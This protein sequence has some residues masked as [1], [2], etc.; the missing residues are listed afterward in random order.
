M[1]STQVLDAKG[2][3]VG[4]YLSSH[5]TP[6]GEMM[7]IARE[8]RFGGGRIVVPASEVRRENDA[9]HLP[10]SELSIHEAP[11]Y[12][13]NVAMHA[14]FEF[15]KRLGTSNVNNLMIQSLPMGSGSVSSDVDVP[16]TPL[17]EAVIAAVQKVGGGM[18]AHLVHVCVKRGTI[19]LEGY[20]NDTP[21]RLVV[22]EAAASVPGVK[23]IVN[24]LVIR[25]I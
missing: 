6:D 3:Q 11:L 7:L 15:W 5:D 13:S 14:Y 17:Q 4:T 22:A 10:Y 8:G 21:G 2:Q 12:S 23:E 20:Q 24:M 16:D 19:L 1:Q 18:D 25:S 9:W